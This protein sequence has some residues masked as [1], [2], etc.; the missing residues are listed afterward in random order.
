MALL[1][2]GKLDNKIPLLIDMSVFLI[3]SRLFVLG[4][5]LK[6][7]PSRNAYNSA[8]QTC[9]GCRIT[10]PAAYT[11]FS[12]AWGRSRKRTT[13]SCEKRR[14]DRIGEGEGG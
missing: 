2:F 3:S 14:V 7:V 11:Y 8:T 1:D 12:R 13:R 9:D 10:E 5:D 6:Y 4:E